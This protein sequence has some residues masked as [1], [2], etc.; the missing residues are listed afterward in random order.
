[1]LIVLNFICNF[2][3]G[4]IFYIVLPL[5]SFFSFFSKKIYIIIYYILLIET[6]IN[7]LN[8]VDW[9]VAT[10]VMDAQMDLANKDL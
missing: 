2:K 8:N 9:D 10:K 1:M 3:R 7:D 4:N 5:F 6:A